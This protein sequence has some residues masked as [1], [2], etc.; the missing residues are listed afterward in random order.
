M[1]R[2]GL[3]SPHL[4]SHVLPALASLRAALGASGRSSHAMDDPSRLQVMA[5]RQLSSQLAAAALKCVSA[6]IRY[7]KQ[8]MRGLSNA[9][10][11]GFYSRG[12]ADERYDP[13]PV[14]AVPTVCHRNFSSPENMRRQKRCCQTKEYLILLLAERHQPGKL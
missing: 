2:Q 12:S 9:L 8:L 11:L 3:L 14:V 13:Y 7:F 10:G 6:D 5:A 1:T 4:A